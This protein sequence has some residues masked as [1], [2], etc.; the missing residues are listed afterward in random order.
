MKHFIISMLLAFSAAVAL[1]GAEVRRYV[2]IPLEFSDV[3]F[4]DTRN[5]IDQ[6]ISTAKKY[7][8][9]QFAP[10][11]TFDFTVTSTVRL[12]N[13]QSHYGT[14]YYSLKDEKLPEA[15]REALAQVSF[16]PAAYDCDSDGFIDNIC[17]ISAGHSESDG[18]GSNCIWPQQIFLHDRGGTVTVGGKTADSFSICSEFSSEAIFCHE[19]AHSFGLQDTYDTDG[20]L[21]GGTSKGLWGTLS[22]MDAGNS[23]H[24]FSAVELD[25]L[26]LGNV[27]YP[28]EG[29]LVLKPLSESKEYIKI[30]SGNPDEYFLLECR[31]NKG[32]DAG[33]GGQ[34]LVIYHVDRSSNDA[35]YSDL[36][37][38]NLTA[39]ERWEFNQV[40]CRPQ[41]ECA[42]VIAAVPGTDDI[43]QVFFPQPG[44]NSFGSETDPPM[45]SWSGTTGSIAINNISY[46]TSGEVT[47]D[48]V[49][50]LQD[51]TYEVF[52]DAMIFDWNIHPGLD[53]DR[54]VISW[55]AAG[56][57]VSSLKSTIVYPNSQGQYYSVIEGLSP[58]TDYKVTIRVYCK[59]GANF[60]NAFDI[61]TKV[62]SSGSHPFI[63]LNTAERNSD[64]T[65]KSGTRLPLR[66]YNAPDA[67]SV[68]WSF[69]GVRI[70]AL[71]LGYWTMNS[72]GTLEAEIVHADGSI[73]TIVKK[74]NLR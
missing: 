37:R 44:H 50:P 57:S 52:Q 60:S 30:P 29:R 20:P 28:I 18:G 11:C 54:S 32:W 6:K 66:V 74:I 22:L 51:I 42:R 35:M 63:Y 31:D 47:L 9:S 8:D 19:L 72:S 27:I 7:F 5:G 2:V 68:L 26:G 45:R 67:R 3:S 1:S 59:D 64:G 17:F 10:A 48:I 24:N 36:Y 65:F 12:P 38:R 62:Y 53:I 49:T 23:L 15:V 41:H 21:S 56:Q 25:Q 70:Y 71:D 16:D 69:N 46:S 73:E 33:L 34:G 4:T 58:Q 13:T 61:R 39:A 55:E 40:N 43:S 14:N